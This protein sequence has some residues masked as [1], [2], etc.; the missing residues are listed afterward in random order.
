MTSQRAK[1]WTSSNSVRQLA[2]AGVPASF[3]TLQALR[4]ALDL[5][6]LAGFTVIDTRVSLN[7]HNDGAETGADDLVLAFGC[8]IFAG[9]IDSDDFPDLNLYEGDW[10]YWDKILCKGGGAVNVSVVPPDSAFYRG[11]SKAS[12]RISDVGQTVF[13]AV[14]CDTAF[15]VDVEVAVTHLVL[16]P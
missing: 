4:T 1:L 7:V 15:G 13:F 16:M 9:S 2:S 14:E 12:R 11:R 10:F 5:S 3:Q 6:H 8:G